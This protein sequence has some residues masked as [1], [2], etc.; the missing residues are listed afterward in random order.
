MII[1]L[2]DTLFTVE[3]IKCMLLERL[4]TPKDACWD[5]NFSLRASLWLGTSPCRTCSYHILLLK[6]PR[7]KWPMPTICPC[8]ARRAGTLEGQC[9]SSTHSYILM[10]P[11]FISAATDGT[12]G[13]SVDLG[14]GEE[15]L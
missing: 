12:G 3:H 8:L 4:A 15:H 9:E 5:R 13:C 1:H 11:A 7:S 10:G 14:M 6:S 2:S